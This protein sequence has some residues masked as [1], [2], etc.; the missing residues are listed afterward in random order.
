[1]VDTNQIAIADILTHPKYGLVSHQPDPRESIQDEIRVM[2][3]WGNYHR[4]LASECEWPAENIDMFKDYW[5][6]MATNV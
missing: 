1:M 6:K 3:I 2:D 4:V 5:G